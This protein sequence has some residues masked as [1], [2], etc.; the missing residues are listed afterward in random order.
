MKGQFAGKVESKYLDHG[1]HKC[2]HDPKPTLPMIQA[3]DRWYVDNL[4]YLLLDVGNIESQWAGLRPQQDYHYLQQHPGLL[5]F[6]GYEVLQ[7]GH[8][9]LP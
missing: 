8:H 3:M 7:P 1:H 9:M 2:T 5:R 6:G 4:L